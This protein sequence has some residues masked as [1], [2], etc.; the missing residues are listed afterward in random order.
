LSFDGFA[1]DISRNKE[2]HG[3]IV[4]VI[5][6]IAETPSIAL[7][8]NSVFTPE[9]VGYLS[10][11]IQLL[12]NLG[13]PKII[14]ALCT[15]SPWDDSSLL[16][17][18][19][20]LIDLKRFLVSYYKKTETVPLSN[21]KQSDKKDIFECVAGR[22]QMALTPDGRLWGCDLFPEYF[23]GKEETPEYQ[24]YCFGD[25][26]SFMESHEKVYPEILANYSNLRLDRFYTDYHSCNHCPELDECWVCPVNAAFASSILGKIPDWTCKVNKIFRE[27]RK[28]FWEELA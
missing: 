19:N 14:L 1:Q 2:S 16:R 10:K 7:E 12:V 13:V 3:Q 23:K 20:E 17:L 28:L 8:T 6:K 21:F 18:K 5:E 26:N 4:S 25:L 22:N 27:E 9:T 24:K 15:T 11:S